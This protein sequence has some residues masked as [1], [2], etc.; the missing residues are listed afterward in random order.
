MQARRIRL[1]PGLPD[2]DLAAWHELAAR[3]IEPNPFFEPRFALPAVEG[4]AHG[5]T[6]SLLVVEDGGAWRACMP[7][8]RARL[9]GVPT[10][11]SW[12]HD[13]GFL[14][15]PLVD[16]EAPSDSLEA[17]FAA[18]I[19]RGPTGLFLVDKLGAEGP[20]AAALDEAFGRL[21]IER[22]IARSHQ[23]AALERRP[24]PTYFEHMRTKHR[25]EVERVGRRLEEELGSSEVIDRAGD[26]QAV[27][28]FLELES[29]GWKSERRTALGSSAAHAQFFRELCVGYAREG[30]LQLLSLEVGGRPL[31]MKCNLSTS[32]GTFCFK[33]AHDDSVRRFSPGVQLERANVEIFHEQREE[34]WQD[35]C[36]D[37]DN[38][39]INR[40]WPDRRTITTTLIG[41]SG[42]RT[43]VA[44][45]AL[46]SIR[47]LRRTRGGRHQPAAEH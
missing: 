32:R 9:G 30:R 16:G 7:V 11:T 21:R 35:S 19:G 39:M 18:A 27:E 25:R 5:G 36:A 6:V 43:A 2:S 37:P 14:G 13:Y 24:E 31:A 23:R 20:V 12:R 34:P 46:R 47:A 1:A 22:L 15:T 3:A 29:S 26:E 8:A 17:L 38:E 33:I 41:K 10:L 44:R 28:R 45:A 4:L 40:L 42:A